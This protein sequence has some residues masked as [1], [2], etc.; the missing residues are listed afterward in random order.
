M[1][2]IENLKIQGL[3]LPDVSARG[4]SYVSVNIRGNI[5][6]IAIQFPILN[7]N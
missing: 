1:N 7:L 4:G 3:K 2:P 5:V 6:Y